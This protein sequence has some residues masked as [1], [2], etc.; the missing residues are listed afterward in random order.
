MSILQK[1]SVETFGSK[2][3]RCLNIR[4][5]NISAVKFSDRV[6]VKKFYRPKFLEINVFWMRAYSRWGLIQGG[7]GLK[8]NC[9][10]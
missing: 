5:I 1:V 6:F 4:T 2:I 7:G 10:N 9:R 8:N 3:L